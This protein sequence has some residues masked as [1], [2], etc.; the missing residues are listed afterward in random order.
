MKIISSPNTT[1]ACSPDAHTEV[2]QQQQAV[3][4]IGGGEN[5]RLSRHMVGS[6]MD[7]EAH[8]I[9]IAACSH[10]EWSGRP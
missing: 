4:L 3:E 7:K 2:C 6:S 5:T 9:R 8:G 10:G 1:P